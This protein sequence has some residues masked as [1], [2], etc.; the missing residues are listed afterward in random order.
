MS[1][2]VRI[3]VDGNY[4][5]VDESGMTAGHPTVGEMVDLQPATPAGP[6]YLLL[7]HR[8]PDG[9]A[10]EYRGSIWY[11]ALYDS[12]LSDPQIAAH[13]AVLLASDDDFPPE[14]P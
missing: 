8:V 6:P 4:F 14:P 7:G 3:Y 2:R 13:A 9:Q 5:P 11:A 12:V 1:D 10:R